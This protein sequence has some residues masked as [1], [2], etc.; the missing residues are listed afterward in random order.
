MNWVDYGILGIIVISAMIGLMRGFTR[1]VF[2]LA[3]WVLAI[4][5]SVLVGP[6]LA[7]AL[8]T[9]VAT[10][11]FRIGLAYGGLFLAGLLMG[12]ILTAVF[13]QRVRES[14]FSSADRTLGAGL[15]LIRGI[16]VVGLV[17]LL[18]ITSGM[19]DKPWWSKS[20][21]IGPAQVVA[22]GVHVFIPDAWLA[23]LKPDPVVP[24]K[25]SAAPESKP[26]D[27]PAPAAAKT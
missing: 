17:V 19:G 21:L 15:G 1:E 5:L 24:M 14:R 8:Q 27:A 16:L 12:G 7:Q 22:D 9:Q 6:M 11:L 4:L 10:P 2:G 18:A 3:T 26:K 23:P 25:P 13:A 20:V